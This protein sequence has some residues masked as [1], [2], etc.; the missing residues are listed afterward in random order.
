MKQRLSELAERISY[1]SPKIDS[2]RFKMSEKQ[3]LDRLVKEYLVIDD[4][5]CRRCKGN[6]DDHGTTCSKCRKEIE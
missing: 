4:Q 1:L 5:L 6:K 2:G 3:E